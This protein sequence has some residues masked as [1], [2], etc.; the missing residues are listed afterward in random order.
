MM[1]VLLLLIIASLSGLTAAPKSIYLKRT[2]H[3]IIIKGNKR[4]SSRVIRRIM[5]IKE[6]DLYDE[7]KLAKDLDA[8]MDTGYFQDVFPSVSYEN[9]DKG[10]IILTL[11][12]EERQTLSTNVGAGY[13]EQIGMMGILG[14]GD[15]NFLGNGQETEVDLIYGYKGQQFSMKWSESRLANLPL[16][17]GV[18]PYY[19]SQKLWQENTCNEEADLGKSFRIQRYGF[20]LP[21]TFL[22]ALS[23]SFNVF[24]TSRFENIKVY[25]IPKGVTLGLRSEQG[26]DKLIT[27][28]FGL[29]YL[30][31]RTSS[32]RFPTYAEVSVE[33]SPTDFKSAYEFHRYTIKLTQQFGLSKSVFFRFS[34]RL[35]LI[36]GNPPFY[37]KYWLGGIDSIRGYQT[38]WVNDKGEGGTKYWT[39]GFEVGYT[40][41][42]DKKVFKR[43][44]IVPFYDIGKA[45]SSELYD[46]FYSLKWGYGLGATFDLHFTSIFVAPAL[47]RE[48]KFKV[49]LGFGRLEENSLPRGSIAGDF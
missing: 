13:D 14:Y 48:R 31:N 6:G 29:R 32:T 9:G 24:I 12:I 22:T 27:Y 43:V 33:N 39:G 16:G 15:Y 28:K 23:N 36:F 19:T 1:K 47:N 46:A 25:D 49:E 3:K 17:L 10:K 34:P 37:E 40:I 42:R 26:S 41:A 20:R 7:N 45:W 2:V 4:T 30:T 38:G 44:T 8:L 11:N 35:G 21:I 5:T 18:M